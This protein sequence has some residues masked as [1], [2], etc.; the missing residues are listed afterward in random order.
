MKPLY[1]LQAAWR[2]ARK[3]LDP[4]LARARQRYQALA[5]RERRL[6]SGAAVLLGAAIVFVGLIEPALNTVRKLQAELPGLRT[7]AAAVADL[8]TQASAL[9]QRTAAPAAAMPAK[10]ELAASLERA[11]LPAGQWALDDAQDGGVA[12]SLDQAP[13]SALMRWL[14]GA[15]RDWGLAISQVDLTRAANAN[16]RPLP[17]LVNGK[18]VLMPPQAAG[19]R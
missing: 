19:S 1:R 10:A 8:T 16:G 17:G 2:S 12:L 14:D 9:R 18:V 11:G 7:Q 4:A 15:G 13:S 6:V 5:P 3:P